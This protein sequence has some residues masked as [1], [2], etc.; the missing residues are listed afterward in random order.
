M[1]GKSCL[2]NLLICHNSM[3]RMVDGGSPVDVIYLDFQKA[4]DKVPHDRLMVKIQEAGISG[5][6]ADSSSSSSSPFY[7]NYVNC[8][9]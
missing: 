1:K 4:F 9:H 3:V 2:S 6:L 8:P 5:K 7:V